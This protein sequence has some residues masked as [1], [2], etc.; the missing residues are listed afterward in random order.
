[1]QSLHCKPHT[2]DLFKGNALA[3]RIEF[4][5][6]NWSSLQ[7][8]DLKTFRLKSILDSESKFQSLNFRRVLK[9]SLSDELDQDS[10][11]SKPTKTGNTKDFNTPFGVSTFLDFLKFLNL[12]RTSSIIA[13]H[14]TAWRLI[15]RF[16]RKS[17]DFRLTLSRQ[18]LPG[19]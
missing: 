5:N 7:F 12:M 10:N 13:V 16:S 19:C 4:L 6:E 1:M 9:W 17:L 11:N 15:F 2:I 18:P 8:A 14:E 3:T